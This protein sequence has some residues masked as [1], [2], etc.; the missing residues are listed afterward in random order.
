MARW[1]GHARRVMAMT[2]TCVPWRRDADGLLRTVEIPDHLDAVA[3]KRTTLE[4]GVRYMEFTQAV[5]VSAAEGR[6]VS[7]P[8]IQPRGD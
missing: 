8:L 4:E 1:V 3:V 5:A 2:K 7:L 6:A